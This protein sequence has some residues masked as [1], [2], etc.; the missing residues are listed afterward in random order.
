MQPQPVIVPERLA[1]TDPFKQLTEIVGCGPFR[2]LPD[3]YV[4][5]I[6]AAFA[7][8]DKYVPR[9]EPASYNAG[10]HKV[11]LDR[12][13]WRVI[14]DPATA[15]NAL[16]AGEVDWVELPQPDLIPMLAKQAGVTTGLLDIYGTVAILRPNSI[17]RRPPATSACA[18]R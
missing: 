5:G 2:F 10:G 15:A 1:A 8:F 11:L 17:Y 7:R 9:Q 6:H 12:V 3:E 13:E 14:P 18:A 4:S 16:T